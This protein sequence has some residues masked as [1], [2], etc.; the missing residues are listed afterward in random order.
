MHL[1]RRLGIIQV[2]LA[3]ALALHKR[4]RFAGAK[5]RT[6]LKTANYF[7]RKIEIRRAISRVS[8]AAAKINPRRVPVI[9]L[10]G[11]PKPPR[12]YRSTLRCISAPE[13]SRISG[14]QPSLTGLRELSTSDVHDTDVATDANGLLPRFLTL[15]SPMPRKAK[16]G[17]LFSSALICPRGQLPVRKR[18]A[19]C[20]PDF[21][22]APPGRMRQTARLVS[23]ISLLRS[24]FT[25]FIA[26]KRQIRGK[27]VLLQGIWF[28]KNFFSL[29]L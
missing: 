23:K 14:E 11:R 18:S 12:R 26:D 24:K 16:E 21:P 22:H 9:Y 7:I 17:R 5:L 28:C 1:W 20:C 10:G 2:N 19:L 15:T 6:I 27:N 4:S 8:Y 25:I 13:G 3:S 29:Y